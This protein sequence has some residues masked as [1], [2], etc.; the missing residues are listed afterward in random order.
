M[1]KDEQWHKAIRAELNRNERT[2]IGSIQKAIAKEPEIKYREI[3]RTLESL[4]VLSAKHDRRG[5]DRTLENEISKAL[6]QAHA[7]GVREGI[8]K[9]AK[10]SDQAQKVA[11]EIAMKH[12][13]NSERRDRMYARAREAMYIAQE[14]R[15]L[16]KE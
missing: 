3:A 2:D 5:L 14:I 9:A 7:A 16:I 4:A 11:S 15:A 8:E 12:P 1:T 6:S 10:V 13:E